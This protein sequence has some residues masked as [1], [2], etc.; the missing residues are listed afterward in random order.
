MAQE[1]RKSELIAEIARARQS[2]TDSVRGVSCGLDFVHRA[3]HSI[4]QNKLAWISGASLVGFILAKLPA[5]TKKVVV[6]RK[7]RPASST[8][9]TAVKA[10]LLVTALKFAFDLARP[11]LTRWLTQRV[12]EY[13]QQRFAPQRR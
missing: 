3:E 5:R 13:A 6:D 2:L 1:L 9:E 11:A 4:A 12:T 7:G 8:G 10:G